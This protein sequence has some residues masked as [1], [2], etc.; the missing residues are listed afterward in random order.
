MAKR[1]PVGG[2]KR[3]VA[4]ERKA[5]VDRPASRGMGDE[6]ATAA[7]G[8]AEDPPSDA[9]DEDEE[10]VP[11]E[12]LSDDGILLLVAGVACLLAAATARA[13]GQPGSVVVFGAAAAVVALPLFVADLLSAYVPG[14]RVHLLVGAAAAL[15]GA[16]ALPGGH[17]LN[18][19]T[20]GAAAAL[21]LWRVVDVE[22]LGAE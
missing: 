12:G 5:E 3:R 21:V 13:R 1:P 20:F 9:A 18:A 4:S 6:S 19:T 15:A 14:L 10:W 8:P 17:Y 2:S 16:L 7:D 22:F 11:M